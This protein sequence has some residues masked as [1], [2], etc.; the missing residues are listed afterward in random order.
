MELGLP[1]GAQQAALEMQVSLL[2]GHRLNPS[3]PT[4]KLM[5]DIYETVNTY[6]NVSHVMPA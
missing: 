6:W 3:G 5:Q 1:D 2:F 4:T